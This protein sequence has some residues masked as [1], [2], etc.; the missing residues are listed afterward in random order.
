MLNVAIA[1]T[2]VDMRVCLRQAVDVPR[3]LESSGT[4]PIENHRYQNDFPRFKS[5]QMIIDVSIT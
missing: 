2:R 1:G 4:V 3:L 5:V